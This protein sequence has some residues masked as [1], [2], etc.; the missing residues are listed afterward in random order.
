MRVRKDNA[1]DVAA[2]IACNHGMHRAVLLSQ[3]AG[4]QHVWHTCSPSVS[5]ALLKGSLI[6]GTSSS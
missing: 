2:A 4:L 1:C 6:V 5:L 3:L